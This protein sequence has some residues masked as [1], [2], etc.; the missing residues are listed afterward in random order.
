MLQCTTPAEATIMIGPAELEDIRLDLE[1]GDRER[2]LLAAAG[3]R[4]LAS[5]VPGPST[6]VDSASMRPCIPRDP[7]VADGG[8]DGA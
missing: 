2:A 6:D 4:A 1:A 7:A 8:P 5:G 3:R